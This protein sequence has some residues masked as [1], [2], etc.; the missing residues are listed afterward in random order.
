MY[1]LKC[2]YSQWRGFAIRTNGFRICRMSIRLNSK[3]GIPNFPQTCH[4]ESFFDFGFNVLHY[5][6]LDE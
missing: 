5:N 3:I 4:T 1:I 6:C 2:D